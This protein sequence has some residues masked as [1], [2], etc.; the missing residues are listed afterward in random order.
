MTEE[1]KASIARLDQKVGDFI[2]RYDR[3]RAECRERY[4]NERKERGDWRES[5]E[6]KLDQL[7][8]EVK[9]VV[10]DHRMV[11]GIGKWTAKIGA[12]TGGLFGIVKLVEW[13]KEHIR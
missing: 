5:I 6:M 1:D 7:R 13:L 8:E 3:D 10:N 4:N 12:G 2:E 11:M 9:P